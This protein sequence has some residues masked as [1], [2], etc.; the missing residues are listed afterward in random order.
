MNGVISFQYMRQ[1]DNSYVEIRMGISHNHNILWISLYQYNDARKCMYKGLIE[2]W[3]TF[4][5]IKIRNAIY[6]KG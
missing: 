4:A 2:T 6:G 5:D 1:T 3:I